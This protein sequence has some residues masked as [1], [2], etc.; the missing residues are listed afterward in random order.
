VLGAHRRTADAAGIEWKSAVY[1]KVGEEVIAGRGLTIEPMVKLARVSS[2]GFY[3]SNEE[4]K[5]D[6]DMDLRDAIQR[7]ALEWP[8]YGRAEASNQVWCTT[9]IAVAS[10]QERLHRLA[11]GARNR[12]QHEPQRQPMDNAA[13]E[14][15]MKTLKYEEVLR[16][17]YR[18]LAEALALIPEFLERVYNQTRLH[19]ALGYPPPVEFEAQLKVKSRRP[20][21]GSVLHEF[22]RQCVT[23]ASVSLRCCTKDGGWPPESA[24]RSRLQTS[25]HP[26]LLRRKWRGGERLGKRH[27]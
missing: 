23:N 10:T 12:H 22:S 13:C 8:S 14:S 16:N 7:I 6:R 27:L 15:Y 18:D 17:E 4:A 11:E 2:A 5:S 19:S 3:R 26:V 9:L 24:C 21:P 20:L 1:G 25:N